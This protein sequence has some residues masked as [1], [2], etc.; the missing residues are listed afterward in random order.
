MIDL[1]HDWA[2]GV[3]GEV[4]RCSNCGAMARENIIEW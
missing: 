4:A 2:M 1:V 3:A